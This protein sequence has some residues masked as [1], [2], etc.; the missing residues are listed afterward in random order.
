MVAGD[1]QMHPRR[2]W[3][4]PALDTCATLAMIAAAGAIIW[5]AMRANA[6][7]A[8]APKVA[9]PT[10]PLAVRDAPTL[11]SPTA[12][13]AVLEF[14]DFQCPFCRKFATETQG[15]L[16]KKYVDSG[17]VLWAFRE[18]P[19]QIH[20]RAERAAE[21]AEC[22]RLQG[23]FWEMHDTLFAAGGPLADTDI[24]TQGDA[25]GASHDAFAACL[26]DP[27]SSRI[28]SDEAIAKSLKITGTPTFVIGRLRSD[29]LLQASAVLMGAR[30]FTDFTEVIDSL[31][32]G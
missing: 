14:S 11:G 29:G 7:P 20:A 8:P 22:A 5:T 26:N 24:Q 1:N 10:A 4:R 23:K 19:L 30:P 16:R 3:L 32:K 13:V 15:L 18:M 25:A 21:G 31:L 2:H 27:P 17:Q 6:S 28:A 12:P 9:I